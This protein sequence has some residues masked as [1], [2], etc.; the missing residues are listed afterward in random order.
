MEIKSSVSVSQIPWWDLPEIG[1]GMAGPDVR[2]DDI[3]RIL[4]HDRMKARHFIQVAD[5]FHD[6]F[7]S[8]TLESRS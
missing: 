8:N 3:P 2:S 4:F 1:D 6:Q 5:K 7:M